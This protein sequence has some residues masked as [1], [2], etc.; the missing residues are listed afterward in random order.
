M[1]ERTKCFLGIICYLSFCVVS[2]F[3]WKVLFSFNNI[4]MMI[5]SILVM[6][7]LVIEIR[8]MY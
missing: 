4:S 1:V 8:H 2:Y 7:D 5:Y 3:T 6:I